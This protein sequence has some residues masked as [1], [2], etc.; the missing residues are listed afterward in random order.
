LLAIQA[1]RKGQLA[2]LLFHQVDTII[3]HLLHLACFTQVFH[4]V[5][6]KQQVVK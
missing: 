5:Q 1:E 2:E 3:T 6:Q 4:Q